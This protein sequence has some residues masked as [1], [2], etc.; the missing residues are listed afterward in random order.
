[1]SP[2]KFG[3][4][5]CLTLKVGEFSPVSNL[6]VGNLQMSKDFFENSEIFPIT[7]P[8]TDV[9]DRHHN[10]IV[11][12]LQGKTET[13]F[14][15]LSVLARNSS[16]DGQFYITCPVGIGL[17][18]ISKWLGWISTVAPL[19]DSTS[20]PPPLTYFLHIKHSVPKRKI[21]TYSRIFFGRRP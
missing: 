9:K 1:M 16:Q 8:K 20:P 18:C 21:P 10:Q 4:N 13:Q 6:R 2:N 7:P 11:E 5:L 15:I 12:A 17:G 3:P 14:I 19:R